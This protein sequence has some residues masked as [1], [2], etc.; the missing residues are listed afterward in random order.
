MILL[1]LQQAP[2]GSLLLHVLLDLGDDLPAGIL[3]EEELRLFHSSMMMIYREVYK[4]IHMHNYVLQMAF[5][6]VSLGYG[7]WDGGDWDIGLG[8]GC[9]DIGLGLGSWDIGLGLGFWDIGLG[10]GLGI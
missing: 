3:G 10:L 8:L 5:G 7:P 1:V 4:H 6:I 2:N 9:W